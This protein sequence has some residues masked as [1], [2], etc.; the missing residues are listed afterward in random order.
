MKTLRT[1]SLILTMSILVASCSKSESSDLNQV[2]ANNNL[3]QGVWKVSYFSEKGKDE[4]SNF[5]GYT[6]Q[7]NDNGSLTFSN[8]VNT[9]SGTW[10]YDHLSDDNSNSSNKLHIILTGSKL[11]D[12]L[13]DDWIIIEMSEN[14]IQLKDDN[15]SSAE[16][17][18]LVK[19]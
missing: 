7:F 8:S 11:A 15:T 4:T 10:S 19:I 3:K 17:L 18:N 2:Q 1:L 14:S 12:E 5:N 6:L 9:L 16:F 13:Q